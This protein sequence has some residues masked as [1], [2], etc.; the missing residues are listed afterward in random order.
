MCALPFTIIYLTAIP[1]SKNC[2]YSF[3]MRSIKALLLLL[4]LAT[5]AL[6][7]PRPP[8]NIARAVPDF[9]QVIRNPAPIDERNSVLDALKDRFNGFLDSLSGRAA[10]RVDVDIEQPDTIV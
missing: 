7:T 4:V 8:P 2:N 10:P 5:S 1:E 6:T 9:H 3:E